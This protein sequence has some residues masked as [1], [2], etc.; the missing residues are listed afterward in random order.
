MRH[1]VVGLREG[2]GNQ[3]AGVYSC[4]EGAEVRHTGHVLL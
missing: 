1:T 3:L 4:F 2:S